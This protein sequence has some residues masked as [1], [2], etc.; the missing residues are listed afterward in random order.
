MSGAL[1]R[2]V[3]ARAA[4]LYGEHPGVE[5]DGCR[6]GD[7]YVLG[8]PFPRREA[9]LGSGFGGGGFTIS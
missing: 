9:S 8:F 6:D 4:V 7:G 1:L 5:D 3:V 2:R